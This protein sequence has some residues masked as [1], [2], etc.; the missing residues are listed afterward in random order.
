MIIETQH[1]LGDNVYH[2]AF[3]KELC[4]Q[5]N[6]YLKTP[7]TEIY[8]DLNVKFI[9]ASTS[10][11]TQA[12]NINRSKVEFVN[13]PK[14]Q[15]IAPKYNAVHLI[16]S[17][18]IDG[19]AQ[20]YGFKPDTFDMP[21]F[22][23]IK[24]D[25][26]ICIIRPAT[27]RKEWPAISRNPLPEYI[28]EASKQAMADY[29][30]ISI[31]DID[32]ANEIGLQPLPIAHEYYNKGE[33]SAI[34]LI[35]MIQSADLVIGGVGFIVPMCIA[36]NI[37]LFCI[38]GGNGMYNHPNKITHLS[39]DLRKAT[40]CYP[41]NYCMCTDMKHKCNKTIS[42]FSKKFKAYLDARKTTIN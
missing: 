26:P 37:N 17:N 4:K 40:F 3:V 6:V 8:Q 15:L 34:E 12:K 30:V 18:M 25:K 16:R 42:N 10:L 35:G 5:Y 33:L 32:D 13:L 29:H 24:R 39:M 2:R 23:K 27:I 20:G 38:L 41:D 21:K 7:F 9:K 1:G 14:A 28:Y 19:L 11:R 36:S 22:D 31:A